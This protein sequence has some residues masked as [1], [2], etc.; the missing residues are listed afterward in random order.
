MLLINQIKPGCKQI[1]KFKKLYI[2][3]DID[4]IRFVGV[5]RGQEP[6]CMELREKEGREVGDLESITR[7]IEQTN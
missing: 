3:S 2:M 1:T 5:M 7:K 6:D 4:E